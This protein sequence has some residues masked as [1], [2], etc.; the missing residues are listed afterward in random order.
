MVYTNGKFSMYNFTS[1]YIEP[2]STAIHYRYY[3]KDHLGNNRVVSSLSG[4]ILQTN[5]YYPYGAN[6]ACSTTK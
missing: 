6:I 4:T 3:M 5:H 1:G 2:L